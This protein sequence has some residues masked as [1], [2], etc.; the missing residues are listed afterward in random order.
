MSWAAYRITTK[1]E[2]HARTVIVTASRVRQLDTLSL[3]WR[4]PFTVLDT[5]QA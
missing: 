5:G 2:A 3:V 4:I 1:A